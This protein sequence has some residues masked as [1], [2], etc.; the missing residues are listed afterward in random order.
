[1][2]HWLRTQEFPYHHLQLG[3]QCIVL[4]NFQLYWQCGKQ[5]GRAWKALLLALETNHY[6]IAVTAEK[7]EDGTS[8]E[9]FHVICHGIASYVPRIKDTFTAYYHFHNCIL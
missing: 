7:A 3:T 6:R 9:I 1:M 4:D 8:L 5:R 2:M